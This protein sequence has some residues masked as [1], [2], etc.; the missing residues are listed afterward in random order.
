MK[1]YQVW[2]RKNKNFPF[3]IIELKALN[4]KEA[5]EYLI[6]EGY[7]LDSKIYVKK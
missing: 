1:T 4:K 3:V 7:Q 5:K 6:K 2:G